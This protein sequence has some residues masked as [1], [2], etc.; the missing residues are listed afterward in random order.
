MNEF[1]KIASQ[2]Q[3]ETITH[4]RYIHENAEVGMEL[5]KTVAYIRRQLESYGYE[6]KNCGGGLTCTVGNSGS[7]LMLRADMDAL[8][9]TEISGEPFS[10]KTGACHSCGH[11]THAAMLLTA[12]KM[13]KEREQDL[14]GTVKFMFE[15][16]EEVLGGARAMIQDGILENPQVDAAIAMHCAGLPTG[17]LRVFTGAMRGARE[18]TVHIH[19]K[20]SHG[21]APHKGVS[22]LSVAANIV[23]QVQQIIS[24]ETDSEEVSILTFG[25]FH[26]GDAPNINPEEAILRGTIR[27]YNMEHLQFLQDRF[28]TI[29]CST[30]KA[31]RAFAKIDYGGV[32][33]LENNENLVRE[34]FSYMKE[35]SDHCI[36]LEENDKGTDDFAF[37]SQ[38]VPSMQFNLGTGSEEEGY[39]Y[40][41]HDPRR[42]LNE[43]GMITGAACLANCAV[44]WLANHSK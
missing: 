13:L 27:A 23:V 38:K 20:A 30:A 44:K 10:C 18:F 31:Y 36:L 14:Q 34:M 8:P 19:G 15:S 39:L 7:V 4:R 16:G 22:A 2:L 37:I 43:E 21:A 42:T 33:P 25:S 12:A 41:G 1:L 9:Q 11:D 29:V 24:M 3:V 26:A 32:V 28:E 5:P 40:A 35:V 17:T 6:V